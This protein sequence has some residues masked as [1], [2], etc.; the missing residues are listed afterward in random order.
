MTMV[1]RQN[2]TIQK[3]EKR[4]KKRMALTQNLAKGQKG[5]KRP[6][7]GVSAAFMVAKIAPDMKNRQSC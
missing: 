3:P 6:A 2:I 1:Q 7:D 4:Q 5:Q